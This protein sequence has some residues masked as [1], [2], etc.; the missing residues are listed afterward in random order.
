MKSLLLSCLLWLGAG[1]A[2][3]Q[4]MREVWLSMPDSLVGYVNQSKRIEALDYRDM[5]LKLDVKNLLSGSTLVDTLTSD[6]MEV[7]LSEASTLQM[8]LLATADSDSVVCVVRTF[9]GPDPESVVDFY[10]RDWQPVAARFAWPAVDELVQKPDTMPTVR[11]EELCRLME[12]VLRSASLSI[13]ENA[14]TVSLA[15]PMLNVAEKEALSAIL[16]Q[17][18]LKWDGRVFK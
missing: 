18:K 13:D 14:I 16:K 1:V 10:G 12:P 2:H 17:R 4:S 11:Y 5:G 8:K 9:L 3:A 15:V 7:R 6:F